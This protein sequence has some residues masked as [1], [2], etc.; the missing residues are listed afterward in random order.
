[1]SAKEKAIEFLKKAKALFDAPPA[2]TPGDVAPAPTTGVCVVSYLV[3]GGGAVYVDCS[4]D[5]IADIDANDKVYSDPAMTVPYPDGA[6]NVTGTDFG[7]TVAGGLV[8]VVADADGTGPG[9]PITDPNDVGAMAKP[10]TTDVPPPAPPPTMEQR[11]AAI[12][13]A[14]AKMPKPAAMATQE[15]F[16]AHTSKF[17][18]QE[19]EIQKNNEIIKALFEMVEQLVALP[20]D[21]PKTLTGA[22]KDRFDRANQREEKFKNITD[23]LKKT[24]KQYA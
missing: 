16:V 20:T 21:E 18:K 22:K 23:A 1:M 24:K 14:L 9:Q 4:D 6:Y 19:K 17:A 2:V 5:C 13:E 11:V 8:T 10:V 7:F 3:D 12:E 15:E